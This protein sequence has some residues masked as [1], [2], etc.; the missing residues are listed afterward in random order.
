MLN[1]N[2]ID[3]RILIILRN[4]SPKYQVKL[5]MSFLIFRDHD[6]QG[7][8]Q[9]FSCPGLLN[10]YINFFKDQLLTHVHKFLKLTVKF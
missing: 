8:S 7:R 6:M 3:K 9:D 5:L 10:K 4:W 2:I 1:W